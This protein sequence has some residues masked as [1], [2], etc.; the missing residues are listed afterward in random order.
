LGVS[1][2][3]LGRWACSAA[4]LP[5]ATGGLICRAFPPADGR[6]GSRS[7]CPVGYISGMCGRFTQSYTW[8]ELVALYRLT[9]PAVN[10]Q[11]RYNVCPTDTI[12]VVKSRDGKPAL[13]PMR[14]G[15]IPWWWKKS[16]KEAPATFNAR[17]E[18]IADK[19]MFRDAFKRSRCIIPASGYYEWKATPAGKQPYY[20]TAADG[21][22]LSIAGLWDQWKDT[23]TGEHLHSC[24]IVV[25]AANAFARAI[26]DRMPVLLGPDQIGAWVSGS[27]GAELLHPAPDGMLRMWPVSKRVNKSTTEGDDPT[28]IEEITLDAA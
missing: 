28:L 1:S 27:A 22:V 25:T 24:T 14:W 18:S 8:R 10:L 21:S 9:Q 23:E 26:H 6:R 4:L 3:D 16:K 2:L 7:A 20:I 13:A 5:G 15:L 11:A 19:P 17:A 12:D